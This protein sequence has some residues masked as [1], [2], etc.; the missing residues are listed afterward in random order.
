MF[1]IRGTRG[2]TE[3][4]GVAQSHSQARAELVPA[5]R[6]SSQSTR[7]SLAALIAPSRKHK[8]IA[9]CWFHTDHGGL[10]S[11]L[12][13][14]TA[15]I[16]NPSPERN[17]PPRMKNNCVPTPKSPKSNLSVQASVCG[18]S[19]GVVVRWSL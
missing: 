14:V 13:M 11:N 5:L 2:F 19:A 3:A 4:G 9:V 7:C 12:G 1:Y 18:V 6:V 17:F 8:Q 10:N 15:P 16:S